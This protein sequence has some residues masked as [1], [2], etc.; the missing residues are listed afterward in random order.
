MAGILTLTQLLSLS[1]A[2]FIGITPVEKE[3]ENFIQG[4][5]TFWEGEFQETLSGE[6]VKVELMWKD[7]PSATQVRWALN[8]LSLAS[9]LA[10]AYL[11]RKYVKWMKFAE[12][13][14]DIVAMEELAWQIKNVGANQS[15]LNA[16]INQVG[17][18]NKLLT[19]D[20]EG[21]EKLIRLLPPKYEELIS[22]YSL[23]S[24]S[25][26][27]GVMEIEDLDDQYKQAKAIGTQ[28]GDDLAKTIQS[29]IINNINDI[30]YTTDHYLSLLDDLKS[31]PKLG[32]WFTKY[33][34]WS[35]KILSV[36]GKVFIIDTIAFLTT[37][38]IAPF[39]SKEQEQ[40]FL[41][42]TVGKTLEPF[43]GD[44]GIKWP[45]GDFAGYYDLSFPL[46]FIDIV[47]GV[48][49]KEALNEYYE[50]LPIFEDIRSLM[51]Y[52]LLPLQE[53]MYIKIGGVSIVMDYD[54]SLDALR[55][56]LTSQLTSF[57]EPDNYEKIMEMFL[58][59]VAIKT[60]YQFYAKP[61]INS[62]NAK[63]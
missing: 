5:S 36:L 9:V 48:A 49:L 29:Q 1:L 35:K 28:V 31:T 26:W 60:V 45:K 12:Q 47:L 57:I 6:T 23:V 16:L 11:I 39:T 53:F 15:P 42:N 46:G 24:G 22:D 41:N 38:V 51:I 59:A 58:G 4:K 43:N 52:A 40:A 34:K 10:Y 18:V 17:K 21:F 62:L 27:E 44:L 13:I 20:N 32:S 56:G 37:L 33:G 25:M 30:Q 54:V 3:L 2:R 61:L 8:I 63:T 50:E 55:L 19:S 14:N 7:E